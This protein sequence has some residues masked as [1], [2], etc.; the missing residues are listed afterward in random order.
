M[1]HVTANPITSTDICY[2]WDPL[3]IFSNF[4][5]I[6]FGVTRL[7]WVSNQ[8]HLLL[9]LFAPTYTCIMR[10]SFFHTP[11]CAHT[12]S[13]KHTHNTSWQSQHLH[14]QI[15][16]PLYTQIHMHTLI[17][18]SYGVLHQ[19][20]RPSQYVSPL[21]SLVFT[22]LQFQGLLGRLDVWE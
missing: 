13:L 17:S 4:F 11:T 3:I 9:S 15:L 19:D 6:V 18:T 5:M 20:S 22:K 14:I 12:N 16:I 8:S 10:H 7:D 21:N 2:T 1:F